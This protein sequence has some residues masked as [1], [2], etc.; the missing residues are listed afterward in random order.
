M[1]WRPRA[2]S[3]GTLLFATLMASTAL[4]AFAGQPLATDDADVKALHEC[5][6]ETGWTRARQHV[7][8][9]STAWT[10]QVGCGVGLD[11]ELAVGLGRSNGGEGDPAT[12]WAFAG[13]TSL[14]QRDGAEAGYAVAW[15]VLADKSPDVPP[16][17]H[18][19]L[20]ALVASKQ[21]AEGWLAHANLGI[22]HDRPSHST[23][24]SWALALEK[25]LSS[26][27]DLT[28]ETFGV[29]TDQP[30]AAL[31][32]RWSACKH[33]VLGIAAT[34][35]FEGPR[36]TVTALTATLGF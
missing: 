15:A 21:L 13:K 23:R 6:W 27:V 33:F 14:R 4:T 9:S 36:G 16:K 25:A 30:S 11:T 7:A 18:G 3:I 32:L 12:L 22:N 24:L 10:T 28:A 29:E 8:P 1:N 31:G 19:W 5:E 17:A 34:R 20:L 2:R 35:Q 26:K